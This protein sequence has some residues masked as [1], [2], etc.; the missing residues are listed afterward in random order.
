MNAILKLESTTNYFYIQ[1]FQAFLK[2]TLPVLSLLWRCILL[3]CY[4]K[5]DLLLHK[6]HSLLSLQV[7]LHLSGL[8]G[9]KQCSISFIWDTLLNEYQFQHLNRVCVGFLGATRSLPG[10]VVP[11]NEHHFLLFS[12]SEIILLKD[13]CLTVLCWFLPY[14]N[15]NQQ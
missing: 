15:M 5:I 4:T 12:W 2:K 7:T 1:N 6:A 14:I 8:C 11:I 10:K 3:I 9:L 13:N